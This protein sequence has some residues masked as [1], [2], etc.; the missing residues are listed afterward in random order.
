MRGYA[1]LVAALAAAASKVTGHP[2]CFI[3]SRAPDLGLNSSLVFCPAAQDGACCT[4]VEEAEVQ[5][6]FEAAGPLSEDCADLYKQVREIGNQERACIFFLWC[7]GLHSP[8]Y[9]YT[10]PVHTLGQHHLRSP[11]QNA[12]GATLWGY[13]RRKVRAVSF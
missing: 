9:L 4:D 2:I 8:H 13:C 1:L 5:A 3:D 12:C 10:S 7:W 11:R 6:R